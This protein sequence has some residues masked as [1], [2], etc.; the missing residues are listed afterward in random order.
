[1]GRLLNVV[2]PEVLF[3]EI[4]GPDRALEIAQEMQERRPQTVV[5]GFARQRDRFRF[6]EAGR[7]GV[8]EIL[9]APFTVD[10]LRQALLA[11][12]RSQPLPVFPNLM[13]FLPAKPG[14][15]ASTAALNVAGALASQAGQGVLLIDGDRQAG[16]L[17]AL[18]KVDPKHSV[19]EAL[20]SSHDLSDGTWSFRE[21]RVHGFDLLGMPERPGAKPLPPWCYYRFL[22]FVQSRY[23]S[24]LVD[25]P[26]VVDIE[27]EAFLRQAAAVHVVCTPEPA[28]LGLA[29]RRLEELQ[30]QG[31]P[32]AHLRLI[33]SRRMDQDQE[34]HEIEK[35]LEMPV[36]AVVPYDYTSVR[37]AALDGGLV[38]EKS[39][40]GGAFS[41]LA[42]KV[43]GLPLP[44]LPAASGHGLRS[45]FRRRVA[46]PA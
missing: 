45:L 42:H 34:S 17:A 44:E 24:I 39:E 38:P 27:Q 18:V 12:F 41:W 25:L 19:L 33:V 43:A 16:S 31:V 7:R 30:R 10:D 15:G 37:Q 26:H 23:D 3:L 20:Q 35:A 11:A 13:I 21:L 5:I 29:R 6:S 36:Y 2:D 46:Q 4:G 22:Q 28:S 14:S 32:E 8:R 1:L 9:V 40:L